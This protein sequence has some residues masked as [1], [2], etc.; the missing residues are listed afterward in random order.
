MA[1]SDVRCVRT[2]R[3][4]SP[5]PAILPYK[6]GGTLQRLLAVRCMGRDPQRRERWETLDQ[7]LEIG[8]GGKFPRPTSD[9]CAGLGDE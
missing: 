4:S 9:R 1:I 8:R 2:V 5:N 3:L 6:M 7:A